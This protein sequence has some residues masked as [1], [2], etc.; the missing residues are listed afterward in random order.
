MQTLNCGLVSINNSTLKMIAKVNDHGELCGWTAVNDIGSYADVDL[1]NFSTND[2]SVLDI[3][4]KKA[5]EVFDQVVSLSEDMALKGT[6]DLKL[7]LSL[8]R[9]GVDVDKVCRKLPH[10]KGKR[11]Y[12]ISIKSPDVV[13]STPP[14]RDDY[15]DH[16]SYRTA[17][18]EYMR[19]TTFQRKAV[20]NGSRYVA[21]V[22]K[23]GDEYDISSYNSQLAI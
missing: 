2:D 16:A 19:D 4:V 7:Y 22:V 21:T 5:C 15:H 18:N 12:K 6:I 1:W 17:M 23:P 9:E 14:D 10:L 8:K 3:A 13:I 20:S 11:H